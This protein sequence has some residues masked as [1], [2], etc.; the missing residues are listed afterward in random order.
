MTK[1]INMEAWQLENKAAGFAGKNHGTNQGI[2]M[3]KFE[4]QNLGIPPKQRDKEKSAKTKQFLK[5]QLQTFKNMGMSIT[6]I[7]VKCQ[8]WY[9]ASGR[10]MLER[11]IIVDKFLWLN[12]LHRDFEG[13]KEVYYQTPE[14]QEGDSTF[15]STIRV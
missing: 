1:A 15:S 13:I 4:T 10:L 5:H 6:H 2:S 7:I 12:Q 8:P 14:D 11:H 9:T 3:G